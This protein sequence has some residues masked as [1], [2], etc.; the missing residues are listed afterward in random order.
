MPGIA[1]DAQNPHIA[2]P[3][4]TDSTQCPLAQSPAV[5]QVFPSGAPELELALLVELVLELVLPVELVLALELVLPVELALEVALVA[6][7]APP[8][9]QVTRSPQSDE[10]W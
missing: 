10:S 9:P 7:P 1:H 8:V 5:L 6:P 4:Q 2:V 3:Q